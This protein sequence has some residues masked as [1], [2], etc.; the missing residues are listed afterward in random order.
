MLRITQIEDGKWFKGSQKDAPGITGKA[1]EEYEVLLLLIDKE[2]QI[3][4]AP[5]CL[6]DI[7]KPT[8]IILGE[9]G[10]TWEDLER[11][12]RKFTPEELEALKLNVEEN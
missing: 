8:C 12:L 10:L 6:K 2:G 1:L 9:E 7:N 5:N 11:F 4:E 3:V